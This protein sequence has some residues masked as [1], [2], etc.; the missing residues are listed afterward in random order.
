MVNDAR[1]LVEE[2]LEDIPNLS[3]S[4]HSWQDSASYDSGNSESEWG[5]DGSSLATG[6]IVVDAGGNEV[7][8]TLGDS[9]DSEYY[10]SSEFSSYEHSSSDQAQVSSSGGGS[11]SRSESIS[12]E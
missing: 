2:V 1:R 11:S 12:L 8:L 5:W 9:G 4:T 7:S 6:D 3:T 10:A